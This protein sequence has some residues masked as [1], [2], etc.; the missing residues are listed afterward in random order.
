MHRYYPIA[1]PCGGPQYLQGGS[2]SVAKVWMSYTGPERLAQSSQEPIRCSD[3]PHVA[4]SKSNLCNP[5]LSLLEPQ[6]ASLP[7]PAAAA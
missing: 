5:F 6:H 7:G 2:P 3:G 4:P 1:L